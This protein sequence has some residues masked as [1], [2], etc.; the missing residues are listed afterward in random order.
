MIKPRDSINVHC[1]NCFHSQLCVARNLLPDEL[2]KINKMIVKMH[3]FDKGMHIFRRNDDMQNLYAVYS[4][5]CK[6]YW[7]DADGTNILIIFIFQVIF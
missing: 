6:D 1:G 7:I 3:Y 5:A 4:G 2:E